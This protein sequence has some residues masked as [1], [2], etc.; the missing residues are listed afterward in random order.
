M[1]YLQLAI[2]IVSL[3]VG[4]T[5]MTKEGTPLLR[6]VV[7]HQHQVAE[8]Y[9]AYRQSQMNLN[10]VYRGNDGTWRYYSDPTNTYWTRVNVQGITEYAQNPTTVR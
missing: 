1:F 9:R 5:Q 7:Q 4:L 6:Q 2:G 3:L 8:Q 10:Y